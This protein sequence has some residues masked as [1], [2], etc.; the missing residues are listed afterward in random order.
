M[1]RYT[2]LI[3]PIALLAIFYFLVIR[4][5]QKKNKQINEM[6]SSL[7]VG[8]EI[9]TIGG[10]YGKITKIKDDMITVE[11][12]A[13]KTKMNITKW[14]VGTTITKAVDEEQK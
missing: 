1:E 12:G 7:R 14:A 3:F 13:D 8:D 10:I 2:G 11:V 4:P 5:Q 6:R 9:T